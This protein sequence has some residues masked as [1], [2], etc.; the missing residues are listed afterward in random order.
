MKEAIAERRL[1]YSK[2]GSS[3]KKE[4]TIG[5]GVPYVD[6][7]GM[8]KCPVEWR[9][10]FEDFADI[11]GMDTLQAVQLASDIDSM[12]RMLRNEYDFF[13]PSGE[14]YFDE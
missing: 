9:G 14:P 8:A 4:L 12:L 13:W 11:C 6:K 1:L 3:A 7:A 2:K 10:L 5:I